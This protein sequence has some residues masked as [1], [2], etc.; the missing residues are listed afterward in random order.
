MSFMRI[1]CGTLGQPVLPN[2]QALKYFDDPDAI[3]FRV[4]VTDTEITPGKLLA[5]LDAIV[6]PNRASTSSLLP[7]R[8]VDLEQEVFKVDFEDDEPVL[9]INEKCGDWKAV[10]HEP[11]FISIAYPSIIRML[12]Y[13]ILSKGDDQSREDN[14]SWQS[15]WISLGESLVRKPTPERLEEDELVLDEWIDKVAKAFCRKF[16]V[17]DLFERH[18]TAGS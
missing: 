18:R 2:R 1:P 13:R 17:L 8:A 15:Q 5:E 16:K 6:D 10:A 7:V 4:K 11:L 12:F 3:K 14:N 9:Y